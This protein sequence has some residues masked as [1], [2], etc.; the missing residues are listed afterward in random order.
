VLANTEVSQKKTALYCHLVRMCSAE[1]VAE[2]AALSV[3]TC[4]L[5]VRIWFGF[6]SRIG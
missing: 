3:T 6:L 4:C 1:I 2:A 5:F